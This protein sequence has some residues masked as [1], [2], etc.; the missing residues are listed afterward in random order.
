MA[1]L[2]EATRRALA[3]LRVGDLVVYPT[4]TLYGLGADASNAKALE[5]LV[6][7]K[8]RE[9][10]KPIAVLVSDLDMLEE[11]VIA[12]P[13]PARRLAEFLWPGPLTL[14]L[15]ARPHVS[16]L[17]TG[18]SGTIGARV[19]SHAQAQAL[20][21]ALGRP[22][23]TPSA[24]PA[25]QT[26]PRR[27]QEAQAYFGDEVA[28]YLDDGIL[29]GEPPSTVVDARGRLSIV[30]PGAIAESVIVAAAQATA[31]AEEVER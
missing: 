20:V 29:P 11:L 18:G 6:R 22:L 2:D 13:P 5:R 31:E 10:G 27:V 23:T 26:P 16:E 12:I 24:N 3:A 8:G 28:C 30:R 7:V 1:D 9:P 14:V 21:R 15:A 19:S 4:E 25:G 17:L